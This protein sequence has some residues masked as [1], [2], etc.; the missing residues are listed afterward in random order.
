MVSMIYR[1]LK[2][3]Q[4]LNKFYTRRIFINYYPKTILNSPYH[5]RI[6]LPRGKFTTDVPN[7]YICMCAFLGR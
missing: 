2:F 7:R 1:N 4:K 5:D 3:Y 6:F